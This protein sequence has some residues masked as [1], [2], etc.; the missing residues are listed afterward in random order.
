MIFNV[1]KCKVMHIGRN[2]QRFTYEMDGQKLKSTEVEKD[3][4]VYIHQ[5][6]TPRVQVAE[7]AKKAN[8]VLGQLL[9]T[10]T[11]RDKVHFVRLYKQR[12]RCH[13]EISVQAWSP[14]LQQDID[15]LENVKK[16]A[17][18][19]IHGLHGTYA[20]KLKQIGLTTLE[21]RRTRGD[22]I[23]TFKIINNYNDVNPAVWFSHPDSNSTH[24]TR[25]TGFINDEG[26]LQPNLY[27]KTPVARLNLRKGFF[28]HRVVSS[29]N[30]L[31]LHVQNASSV[32]SF[33][34]LYDN[35]FNLSC[36]I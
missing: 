27:I 28:S 20:E 14:W 15:I 33:K 17:I 8:Q 12:V 2:N 31:P 32:N 26:S 34:T 36:H 35:W 22:M 10:I 24:P 3:I 19:N 21:D 6:L 7:A 9:R 16:R 5:S 30:K 4:G 1:D 18:R 25:Q 13:L 29:W 23:E 11:F